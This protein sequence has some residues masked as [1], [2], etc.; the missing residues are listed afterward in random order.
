M[1]TR[2]LATLASLLV[3]TGITYGQ[4]QDSVPAPTPVNGLAPSTTDWDGIKATLFGDACLKDR[5]AVTVD[6]QYILWFL[7][8]SHDSLPLSST[9]AFN[10]AGAR[11][12]SEFTDAEHASH[13]PVSGAR[14]GVGYW[15]F[16][17]NPWV[18]GGIKDVGA[19]ASFF[20]IGQRS[21]NFRD[22]A[23]PTQ[24]RPFF[25]LN[26]R[27]DSGF[28]VSMPG[29]NTGSITAHDQASYWGA[30]LN[31]WK[32][33][34][35]DAP[36]TTYSINVGAGFRFLSGDQKLQIGSFSSF[37]SDLSAFP[38]FAGFANN[39]LAVSDTFSTHNRFY[40]GQVGISGMYYPLDCLRIESSFKLALGS[41]VE[42][43]NV[44]GTQVRTL[45]NGTTLV[46]NG[47]L[48]ALPSNIGSFHRDK[49]AQVPEID[50]KLVSPI[51]KNLSLSVGFDTLYWSRILRPAQQVDRDI[52]ITQIPNFPAAA[53][54]MPTG[55]GRPTVA[56][57]QSDV[58]FL[59]I[60][61][62]AEMTW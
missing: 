45:A 16:E 3:A 31:A 42:D 1:N 56:F 59:G 2:Y 30:E 46:S 10:N 6:A 38:E 25:D 27:V 22:D 26:N 24:V 12:L 47:G 8:S 57:H 62:G 43:L 58:W 52:D 28:I 51:R 40:G 17:D 49:F 53:S 61:L 34:D 33:V 13:E 32:N 20:F 11:L 44:A 23:S 55:L 60:T 9:S 4:A 21:L 39:K 36:G 54:A 48:L 5:A 41:T 29:L 18:I 7:A 15:L 35:Y 19:E 37:N 14:F 50:V